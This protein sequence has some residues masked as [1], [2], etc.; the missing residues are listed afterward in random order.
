MNL[1]KM[2]IGTYTFYTMNRFFAIEIFGFF[3]YFFEFIVN[4][5]PFLLKITKF[6]HIK[7]VRDLLFNL[8]SKSFFFDK[9]S[10][11]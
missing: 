4:F 3:Q 1:Y 9:M 11:K 10:K 7:R 2:T 5:A 6:L 8:T